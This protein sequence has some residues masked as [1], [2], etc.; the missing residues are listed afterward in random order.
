MSW[1]VSAFGKARAVEQAI[2]KQF[3]NSGICREPEETIRQAVRS[4]IKTSLA[5]LHESCVV[6]VEGSGSM[7]NPSGGDI[8]S[9]SLRIQPEQG[10]IE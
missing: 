4:I 7:W 9:V 5:P 6:R 8:N 10:F 2:E 3:T 1:S